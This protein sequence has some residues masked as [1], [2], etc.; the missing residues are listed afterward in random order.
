MLECYTA[1]ES[2]FQRTFPDVGGTKYV[3]RTKAETSEHTVSHIWG[4]IHCKEAERHASCDLQVTFPFFFML[5]LIFYNE[6]LLIK[7]G[8]EPPFDSIHFLKVGKIKK[9]QKLTRGNAVVK[10]KTL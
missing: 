3:K 7:N 8:E 2:L 9:K 6:Y 5:F 1:I 10:Q 4:H